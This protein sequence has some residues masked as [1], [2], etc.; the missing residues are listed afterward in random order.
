MEGN[1]RRD[2]AVIAGG[3]A[4]GV[5]GSR[6]LAPVMASASGTV[7][8]RLGADPFDRLIQDHEEIKSIL[9]K[10]ETVGTDAPA[11]RMKLFLALKRTLAKHA[12][13]EEDV[14]YPQ[15]QRGSARGGR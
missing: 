6:L 5:I 14:V 2:V 10:M 13:A 4:V 15:L 3:V 7:R 1:W 8:A 11:Q 9:R 12:M